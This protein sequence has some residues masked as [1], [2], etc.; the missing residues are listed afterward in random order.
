MLTGQCG[1]KVVSMRMNF[2]AGQAVRLALMSLVLSAGVASA[3]TAVTPGASPEW[4]RGEWRVA[5]NAPRY[6]RIGANNFATFGYDPSTAVED[7][8]AA[9]YSVTGERF[10]VR[11]SVAR[12]GG[13]FDPE[14]VISF[15]REGTTLRAVSYTKDGV[16][17]SIEDPIWRRCP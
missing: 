1:R 4:A 15:E 17:Q 16:P 10:S 2:D 11:I 12:P 13:G 5:C 7:A 9:D 6:I 3:Q 8:A 14:Q